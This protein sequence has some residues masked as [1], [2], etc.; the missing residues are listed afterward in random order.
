MTWAKVALSLVL[1]SCPGFASPADLREVQVE[2][3]DDYYRLHSSTW[4]DVDPEALYAVLSNFDLF[5]KF[6]TAIVESRNVE[7]DDDGRPRF[8][9]RMEGCAL[10]WCKSFVRN[11]Y[12]VL[13][14]KKKIMAITDPETSDFKLSRES[15]QLIPEGDGTLLI[16][17]FH[18]IPDFWVPPVIGPFYIK[19]ALKA[20][21]DRAVE[22]IEALAK[23]KEPVL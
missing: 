8:Y 23:G 16:Y 11:G 22:R 9:S 15:W 14:P 19:R 10:L 21:G 6:T 4:F 17:S 7:P 13:E 18:M 2:R 12:L 3:N 1:L 20:G 5:T